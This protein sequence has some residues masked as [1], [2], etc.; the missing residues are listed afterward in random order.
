M[1][2]AFE[3]FLPL[4]L[5]WFGK[6]GPG[7]GSAFPAPTQ[8]TGMTSAIEVPRVQTGGT[9][10]TEW[11][12][13]RYQLLLTMIRQSGYV[14]DDDLA[15]EIA[16][17]LLAQWAHETGRGSAEYNY[18]LGGWR[19]RKGDTYFTARDVQTPGSPLY[20]WT[21]YPD[22]NSGMS[23]QVMRLVKTFPSAAKLLLDEPNSSR[24]VEELGRRGYYG[25][26]PQ[27][28]ARAWAMNRA[29]L[30]GKVQ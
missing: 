14:V 24:W 23:D 9:D 17:S 11:A 25:A 15:A 19:A 18:N 12:R 22:L 28:Y 13:S 20:R 27:G 10:Q 30:K 6:Q 21:A 29:E 4:A 3:Q 8:P 7:G 16:L 5:L 1:Q 26:N 2:S